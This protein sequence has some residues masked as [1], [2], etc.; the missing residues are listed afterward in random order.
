MLLLVSY[1]DATAVADTS[2]LGRPL[3]ARKAR[4]ARE[5]QLTAVLG[6]ARFCLAILSAIADA[7]SARLS[8]G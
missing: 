5:M 1:R 6:A 2:S 7:R 8:A 3:K 4:K